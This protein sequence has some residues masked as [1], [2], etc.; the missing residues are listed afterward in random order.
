MDS[1]SSFITLAPPVFDGINYQSWLVHMEAYL[2]ANDLWEVIENE[3]EVPLL[4][5]S[6]TIS[7]MKSHKEKKQR[8]SKAKVGL[9]AA[10]SSTIFTIIMML[11]IGKKIWDFLKQE[12][13]GNERVKGMHV[14]NLVREFEIQRMKDLE[15]IKNYFDRLLSIANKIRLLGT[16]FDDSRIVQKILVT[17]SERFEV[18]ISSLE[19]TKDLSSITLA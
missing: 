12:Y 4:P 11:K 2:K 5:A 13:E 19:N 6:P 9:F 7:Q 16:T 10:V 18:T 8:N 15:T 14:L 3:Y 1:E 17:I